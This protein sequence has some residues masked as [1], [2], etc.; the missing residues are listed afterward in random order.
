MPGHALLQGHSDEPRPR[1]DATTRAAVGQ[2]RNSSIAAATRPFI[3]PHNP[4][5]KGDKVHPRQFISCLESKRFTFLPCPSPCVAVPQSTILAAVPFADRPRSHSGRRQGWDRENEFPVAAP[6][7][8]T[9]TPTEAARP[10]STELDHHAALTVSPCHLHTPARRLWSLPLANDPAP[11]LLSAR[12]SVAKSTRITQ[13]GDHGPTPS[14][15][16][17]AGEVQHLGCSGDFAVWRVWCRL[18]IRCRA[19]R[20]PRVSC[21]PGNTLSPR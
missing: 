4:R 8:Q 12:A 5:A 21:F 3:D 9:G 19:G 15:V 1:L 13:T 11:R 20:H 17:D 14:L 16:G 10:F 18:R 2:A 7:D 6:S